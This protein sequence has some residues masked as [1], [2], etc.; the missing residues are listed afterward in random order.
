MTN[1]LDKQLKI[2]ISDLSK[3]YHTIQFHTSIQF[4]PRMLPLR[5]LDEAHDEKHWQLLR[6]QKTGHATQYLH[7]ALSTIL[8]GILSSGNICGHIIFRIIF[9]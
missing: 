9:D 6:K 2:K 4:N 3:V 5:L 7:L 8:R 1:A